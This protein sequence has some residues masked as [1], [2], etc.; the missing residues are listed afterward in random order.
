M[1]DSA[2]VVI[3]REDYA[4]PPYTIESID[5]DFQL[6]EELTRVTATSRVLRTQ[7]AA[8]DAPLVLDGQNIQ[9]ESLAIDGRALLVSEYT[10][11][12]ETLTIPNVPARFELRVVSTLN[13][14]TNRALEGLYVSSGNFCTQCEAEGF[15]RITWFLDRPDVMA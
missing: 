13:P 6:G 15:R 4:P 1:R 11:G 12:E 9:L 2:P 8:D 14:L 3:R 10:L 5:L 7:W